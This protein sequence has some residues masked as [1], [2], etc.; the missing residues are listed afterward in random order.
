MSAATKR[1]SVRDVMKREY[2]IIGRMETIH[3]ALL[4]MKK[5][6]TSVLVVDRRN[7]DDEFG[8]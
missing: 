6:R 3:D 5:L 2:G 4:M 1:I 7:K 8:L